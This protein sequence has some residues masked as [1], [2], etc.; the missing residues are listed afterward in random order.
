MATTTSPIPRPLGATEVGDWVDHAGE[1]FRCFAGPIRV[2]PCA[3][4]SDGDPVAVAIDGTQ[5]AD[6][7]IEE[8]VIRL[9]GIT[10][11][12]SMTAETA[13]NIA[14]ALSAAA[15][16]LEGLAAAQGGER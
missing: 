7:T 9:C 13:R 3:R 4:R 14:A 8:R 6:G 5:L 12:D 10:S 16:D 1:R 11:D 2:V 15:D